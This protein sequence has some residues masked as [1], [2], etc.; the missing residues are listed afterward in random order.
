M[1]GVWYLSTP[2]GGR[3]KRARLESQW[4]GTA[5]D[6]PHDDRRHTM[7][8]TLALT[9]NTLLTSGLAAAGT[10]VVGIIAR[11]IWAR[12]GGSDDGADDLAYYVSKNKISADDA[13][14]IRA[15]AGGQSPNV[16]E[17][18]FYVA[19]KKVTAEDAAKLLAAARAASQDIAEVA[20]YVAEKKMTVEDGV[21]L[22]AVPG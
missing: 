16:G 18:A 11:A 1:V 2:G 13:V 17:V 15:A 9:N 20:Y 14:K 6:H 4:A 7:S 5:P 8:A 3:P 10:A 21:K 22:L 12:V 19:D